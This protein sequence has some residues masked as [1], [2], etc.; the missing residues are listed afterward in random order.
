MSMKIKVTPSVLEEWTTVEIASWE[1]H[2]SPDE[3][4]AFCILSRYKSIID[5]RSTKEAALLIKSA[6]FQGDATGLDPTLVSTHQAIGR[7]GDR[8]IEVFG[9]R[10]ADGQFRYT[11]TGAVMPDP[12]K[13][14]EAKPAGKPPEY[15]SPSLMEERYSRE[16]LKRMAREKGLSTA[17]SKRDI[18]N[19]L[20]LLRDSNE[21]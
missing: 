16:Q 7:I 13:E 18:I 21:Q 2:G 5:I 4:H 6:Y 12:T 8:L 10:Y 15:M 11:K 19:R 14:E 17:G 20:P 9:F 3:G 1:D